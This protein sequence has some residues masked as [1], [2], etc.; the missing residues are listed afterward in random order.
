MSNDYAKRLK[1]M[2]ADFKKA[3]VRKGDFSPLPDGKY[4]AKISRAAIE[5]S[6][7]KAKNP[8]A[9]LPT[10]E[11]AIISGD[12]VNRK[13]W[14][15]YNIQ[16]DIEIKLKDGTKTTSGALSLGSLKTD[17]AT[18]GYEDIKLSNLEGVFEKLLDSVVDISLVTR[19]SKKGEFQNC[20]INNIVDAP[21]DDSDIEDDDDEKE[22]ETEEEK[23]EETD[24]D[25]D[26]NDDDEDLE[27]DEDEDD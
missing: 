1:A 10:I 15:R 20:Y 11:M 23:E 14:K 6:S 19:K 18:L 27:D 17:L 16:S 22:E 26:D 8:G 9:L 3:E 13:V 7:K 21:V 25:D 24:S 12:H 2:E 5:V 4:Q